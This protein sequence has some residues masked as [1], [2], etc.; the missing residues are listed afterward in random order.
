M[1]ETLPVVYLAAGQGKRLRP[2]TDDRPKAMIELGGMS[3]AERA[4]RTLREAGVEEVVAITGYRPDALEPLADL[5]TEQRFN[6]RFADTENIYSVWCGRD[7]IASGCYIVNSDVVF[8]REIARRLLSL[9]ETAVLCGPEGVDEESMK[10]VSR[11]GRLVSLSKDAPVDSNPE[12]IGLT[13]VDPAQGPALAEIVASFVEDG[14]LAV[15]YES[16]LQE[17]ARREP[18]GVV[19]VDLLAWIEIDDHDDLG[20]ARTEILEL[21]G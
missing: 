15:Y 4:L 6:E 3:L 13:R 18:V 5:V 2:L 8:E 17:L 11:D 10:A 16:A 20:R 1:S 12:Y 19:S 9:D 7:V 21:V 14:N